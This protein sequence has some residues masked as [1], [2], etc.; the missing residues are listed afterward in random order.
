MSQ[1]QQQI[2]IRNEPAGSVN[3]RNIQYS[4]I[5]LQQ[6]DS[7]EVAKPL[8]KRGNDTN[9]VYDA[10]YR[11]AVIPRPGE[12]DILR[13][14]GRR[15][16]NELL[17]LSTARLTKEKYL[18]GN[19]YSHE[20][21]LSRGIKMH[22]NNGEFV[23]VLRTDGRIVA[24]SDDVEHHLGKSMRILYTQCTNIFECLNE[25]DSGKLQSILNTSVDLAQQEHRLVCTFRLPKGKRPSRT[26][27]DIKTI[28]MAGHFYFCEEPSS[29]HERLFI[30]RCQAL[31]SRTTNGSSSSQTDIVINNNHSNSMITITLNDDMSIN[32]VSSNV[33]DILGYTRNEMINAWFGRFLATDD[34]DK[35]ETLRQKYFQH[36]QQQQQQLPKS[37][38]QIFDIFTNN[39]DGRLTFLCQIRPKRERRSK[40]IKFSIVAQL[41]DPSLRN[42]YIKYVESES[43]ANP[44]PIKAEQVNLVSSS[45][46]KTSEDKIMANSPSLAMGLLM[47]ENINNVGF[48]YQQEYSPIDRSLSNVVAP[49]SISSESI[50][51]LPDDFF[52]YNQCSTKYIDELFPESRAEQLE[53]NADYCIDDLC[54]EDWY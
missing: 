39:G 16:R 29:I 21:E 14:G 22:N 35:F 26:R 1:H 34:L 52:I 46:S 31:V 4:N 50:L 24:M 32:M 9:A 19:K 48:N 7:D 37:V 8:K 49:I 45:I 12:R 47:F 23:L 13:T 2:F 5:N 17:G 40:I 3:Q 30:A 18:N 20:L 27:E 33:L 6:E 42:E 38:C 10:L 51:Q 43:E 25:T 44:K 28:T 36:E 15:N 54:L 11:A 53:F 41:I